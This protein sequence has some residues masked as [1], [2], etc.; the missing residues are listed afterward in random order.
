LDVEGA[1]AFQPALRAN[2]TLKQLHLGGC[3]LEDDGIRLIA[4]ALVG[5]TTMDSL[6]INWNFI[7]PVGLRDITRMIESMRFQTMNFA[8]DNGG[9]FDDQDATQHFVFALQQKKSTIEEMPLLDPLY[10]PEDGRDATYASIKNSLTRNQQ[11]NCVALLLVPPPPPPL[12]L[13]RQQQ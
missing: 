4:D 12:P 2:R 6:N 10:L 11:L 1:R 8:F 3:Y 5:N 9:I 13:Q 7:T